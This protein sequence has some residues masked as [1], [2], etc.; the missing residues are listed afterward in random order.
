MNFKELLHYPD[1][2]RYELL[3]RMRSDCEYF[4]GHGNRQEKYLWGGDVSTHINYMKELWRSFNEKPEW[5][6]MKQ[7]ERYEEEMK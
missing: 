6:T 4:L 3:D 2:F 7:I 1:S 5:L